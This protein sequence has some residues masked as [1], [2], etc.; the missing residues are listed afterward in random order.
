MRLAS[1]SFEIPLEIEPDRP[2]DEQNRPAR[3]RV[4]EQFV[5]EGGRLTWA[6]SPALLWLGLQLSKPAVPLVR[7]RRGR[8]YG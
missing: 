2:G 1:T 6:S 4:L 3:D 7:N 8:H 5:G